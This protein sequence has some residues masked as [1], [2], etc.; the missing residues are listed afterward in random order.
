ME[1]CQSTKETEDL[2]GTGADYESE[3][4]RLHQEYL[5]SNIQPTPLF[6]VTF[7][8]ASELSKRKPDDFEANN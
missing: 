7:S 3:V 6:E 1:D 4:E 5:N 2:E 8:Q